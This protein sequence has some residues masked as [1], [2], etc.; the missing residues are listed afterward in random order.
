MPSHSQYIQEYKMAAC[1]FCSGA[2][3]FVGVFSLKKNYK[4]KQRTPVCRNFSAVSPDGMIS[5]V[6]TP[7]IA[8]ISAVFHPW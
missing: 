2:D 4:K 3:C 5:S 1:H 8:Q 7:V 6:F